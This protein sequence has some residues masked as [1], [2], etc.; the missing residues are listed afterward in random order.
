M[1]LSLILAAVSCTPL[2]I[3]LDNGNVSPCATPTPVLMW[4]HVPDADLAA[5]VVLERDPGGNWSTL[6]EIPCEWGDVDE[7]G[8]ND[9]R[10]CRGADFGLPIQRYCPYCAPFT[11]HE[12]SVLAKDDAGNLSV[13]PSTMISVCFSPIWI[14][15]PY[16]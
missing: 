15:G 16:N 2:P 6:G 14:E 12:F 8:I 9:T 7:D 11:L 5:Y 13:A 1:L 3:C 4:D 10:L